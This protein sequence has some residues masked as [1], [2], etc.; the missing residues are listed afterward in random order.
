MRYNSVATLFSE[1]VEPDSYG[2]LKPTK[3]EPHDVYINKYSVGM[4]TFM[5]AQEAGL[6]ADSEIQLRTIDYNG[7]NIAVVEGTEFTV[8]RVDDT[9]DF[10]RL[11]LAKRLSNEQ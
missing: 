4:T 8:E 9:G 7:E 6:H 10:T 1:V 2:N 5:A 3:G 11:T